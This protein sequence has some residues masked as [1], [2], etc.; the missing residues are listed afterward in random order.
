MERVRELIQARQTK[1]LKTKC[2]Q[3]KTELSA[4]FESKLEKFKSMFTVLKV[5]TF[6]KVFMKMSRMAAK[7]NQ[8]FNAIFLK[9]RR[10]P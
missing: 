3:T 4:I 6:R 7:I 10:K 8:I 2:F 5:K 1:Y 9:F